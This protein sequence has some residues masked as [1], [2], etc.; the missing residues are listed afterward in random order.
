M[1]EF[2]E[3]QQRELNK[4]IEEAEKELDKW[5]EDNKDYLDEMFVEFELKKGHV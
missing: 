3:Q 2:S 5:I 1:I 4:L